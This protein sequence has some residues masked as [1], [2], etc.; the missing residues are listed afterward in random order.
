M[1]FTKNLSSS[2]Y[3]SSYSRTE[4]KHK[5]ASTRLR[6]R[7]AHLLSLADVKINGSRP[8]DIQV[9]NNDLFARIF[10]DGS[11]G[12]GEAY[13][14]GWWD[15]EALD[16]FF[17][18]A[19]SAGLDAKVRTWK[20]LFE[21]LRVRLI[22]PQT[23]SRAFHVGQH[24]YDI[25]NDLYQKM[26]DKRMVYSCG[27]WKDATSLDAAQEAKLDLICRKLELEPGM[28]LLDIGC[29]W[30]GLAAYAAENYGVEVVG[31][32][33]SKEQAKF[34]R[35]YCKDLPVTI[36][37]QD[38]RVVD[39]L[40]DRIVSVG[41]FEH[42]GYKN[43]QTFMQCQ[44]K[45]LKTDGLVL[46]HTIGRNSSAKSVDKWISRYIFPNSMLPS[47]RQ[48]ATAAEGLFFIEDWHSFGT[49]YDRTLLHWFNNFER[50]WESL[51]G[52]KYDDRFYRLWK[53]YLLSCAG[54]FRAR[55]NQLWQVVLAPYQ[56][57]KRYVAPR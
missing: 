33:V 31:I 44:R 34:A 22:N 23:I 24:H 8:W 50:S 39:G 3:T 52:V 16:Q 54:S 20:N 18:N 26:L 2:S 14:E 4:K 9:Y 27:Y 29:G 55:K 43:Y 13:V 10:T 51:R 45:L 5:I 17:F 46:L 40:F 49:D 37:L 28:R 12:L 21:A 6:D 48:I 35:N 32:T 38:Y 41:M 7:C 36:K 15:S 42:V 53:Y 47:A 1:D 57:V 19:L 25:G 56:R 30:G 11:L